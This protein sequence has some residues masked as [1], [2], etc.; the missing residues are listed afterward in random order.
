MS[1]RFRSCLSECPDKSLSIT[2]IL[3]SICLQHWGKRNKIS[4]LWFGCRLWDRISINNKRFS[5]WYFLLDWKNSFNRLPEFFWI[6]SWVIQKLDVVTFFG[7]FNFDICFV[8]LSSIFVKSAL[9][10]VFWNFRLRQSRKFI[11]FLILRFI[12]RDVFPFTRFEV[13]GVRLLTIVSRI[14]FNVLQAEFATIW[15]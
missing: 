15:L 11:F 4:K 3:F 10:L 9:V 14:C 2:K 12:Q 13:T 1:C 6:V 7:L 8:Q 5:T